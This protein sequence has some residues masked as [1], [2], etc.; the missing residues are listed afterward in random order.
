MAE[1]KRHRDVLE[2]VLESCPPS[3]PSPKSES[4]DYGNRFEQS[5]EALNNVQ[6][7]TMVRQRPRWRLA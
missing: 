3:A 2:R 7:V 6:N 5:R 4:I 1:L